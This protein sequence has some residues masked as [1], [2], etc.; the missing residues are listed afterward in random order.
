MVRYA[1]PDILKEI[2]PGHCVI[3]ASA[4]TG[5]TF[6]LEHLII[7]LLLDGIPLEKILVV[8]FTKKA[9][10][11]LIARVRAKL[12]ELVA[13]DRDEWREGEPFWEITEERRTLLGQALTSFD[14]ATINTIHGFCQQVLKDAAF[15][16]AQLF[17]QELISGEEAFDRVFR[18][19]VRTRFAVSEQ[20]L[21]ELALED[22]KGLPGL[23]KFLKTALREREALVCVPE[24]AEQALARFPRS[25]AEAFVAELES[26]E[27]TKQKGS[28]FRECEASGLKI[29]SV[30]AMA[31]RVRQLLE[32][33]RA[34]EARGHRS[35]LWALA[36]LKECR[37]QA[38]IENFGKV[39]EGDAGILA[40][41]F[42]AVCQA[43]VD[44][45]GYLASVFLP[46]LVDGLAR[47][48]GEEGFYDFDD[49]VD[50]VHQALLPATGDSLVQRLRERFRVA[51]IDEFQDTD[52]KQWEIF[53][54]VFLEAGEGHRLILVG[55]PKQAIYGFRGGDLPTYL[56]ALEAMPEPLQLNTNFRS[57]PEVIQ[58]YNDIFRSEDGRSLFTG[59]NACHYEGA[60]R[61]GKP[62]L[63]FVDQTGARLPAVRVVPVEAGA[64]APTLRAC[65]RALAG[66]LRETL[67]R[68]RFGKEG[69]E[70]ALQPED[71]FVLTRS[72]REGLIMAEALKGVGIPA[73]FYRQEG[74]F[75]GFEA[76]ACR[77]LLLAIDSPLQESRRAKALLG[78]FFGLTLG[79]AEG[80][81]ELPENHPILRR[82]FEWRDLAG[83][84]RY[85]ECFNR[86]VSESGVTQR[87]L[88][89]EEGQRRLTNLL[90]ILELLQQE[91]LF[92]HAT[93]LDLAIQVQQWIEGKGRPSVEDGEVQRLER[94]SG[95]VQ[96]LTMHKAKGLEAPVVVLFGAISPSPD[97]DL[98]LYHEGGKGLRRAWVGKPGNA[99]QEVQA[100]IL[101]E[102]R[103]E[104]ERLLYVALTRAKAHLILPR[105]VLNGVTRIDHRHPF[106]PATGD[107]KGAYGGV[108][109][110]LGELLGTPE[111]P[112][113]HP[114]FQTGALLAGDEAAGDPR[115]RLE[116]WK[117]HLPPILPLPDFRSLAV[118]GRP[119]WQFSFS[120]LERGL[121]RERIDPGPEEIRDPEMTAPGGP[122]GGVKLGVQVHAFLQEVNLSTFEGR[123]PGAW[124]REAHVQHLAERLLPPEA[125]DEVLGWIYQ[126]L[127]EELL[128]PDG[129][130]VKLAATQPILRELDFLTPY[131]G[132]PD[133]LDGS[134]DV[135]FRSEG[136]AYLLDWKTN[137]LP[138]YDA[139][140]VQEAVAAHYL[141]QVKIYTVA[142]CRFLGLHSQ[143]AYDAG[144]GG[145]LYVFLRGLP[146]GGVWSLR[147]DWGT[148]QGWVRELEALPV[149][150][151]IPA[152]AGGTDDV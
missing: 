83:G 54:R 135:L 42:L 50:R 104:G 18:E 16:G 140:A 55:D 106:D 107:P 60:V 35:A 151:L 19:L 144:F 95:A 149:E 126:A 22:L 93:P 66:A 67:G 65:A 131:P 118:Q 85:G 79:E 49:M 113:L 87:L 24:E 64:T 114:G 115:A 80:C 20:E 84:G 120:S 122:R 53:R 29:T 130:R 75:D 72:A 145:V 58:A 59:E 121:G 97:S 12:E 125:A 152:H 34:A 123:D 73:A 108:N 37:N 51:L 138:G 101:Q 25:L 9:T 124:K 31:G 136:K 3:K 98:H 147:P 44:F 128:L 132:H 148:V 81:R 13:L 8:T 141:L 21:F 100:W 90:H 70:K 27:A 5:K 76:A 41:G 111:E 63:A 94:T 105:Y 40:Q 47:F 4:G 139:A 127:G 48:K 39:A 32:G 103:E 116:A 142:V 69:G 86:I 117:P 102:E 28:L 1:K 56:Q 68:S 52:R 77:D 6:T 10:L 7:Q 46:P 11:E 74:L 61:C 109:N 91:A 17:Q 23:R 33:L 133:L 43:P 78:P 119:T 62:E 26:Y 134:I 57:T 89:L 99:P 88:F 137:R 110:R 2:G 82:L 143:E 112:R 45:R 146:E 30:K 71:V 15:E 150:R 38:V 14:R 92:R 36:D 96:I 129:K